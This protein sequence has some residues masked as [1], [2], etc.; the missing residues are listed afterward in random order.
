MQLPISFTE[1]IT[2]QLG[3]EA[4][5]FLAAIESTPSVSIR[6]NEQKTNIVQLPDSQVVPW[7]KS[8]FYLE[9]RPSFTADPLFHAGAYY[10][11]EPSSMLIFQLLETEKY[12]RILDLCAAPGG[13]STLLAAAM[14]PDTL[15]VS[16]EIIRSRAGILAENLSRWG[17]PNVLITNN[18]ASDFGKWQGYFDLIVI[19]APC[20]GEGM[21]RKDLDSR[22]EWSPENVQMCSVRQKRILADI[23]PSLAPDGDLIYST[24]TFSEAENEEIIQHILANYP[25]MEIIKMDFPAE[26]GITSTDFGYRCYPHKVRGEGF[27]FCKLHRK[28]AENADRWEREEEVSW[29]K[30]RQKDK[31]PQKDKKGNFTTVSISDLSKFL[32]IA[33]TETDILVAGEENVF[34]FSEA[35]REGMAD[36]KD[37]HWVKK[38]ILLGKIHGKDFVPSHELAVSTIVKS[39]F[40]AVELDLE[41]ALSYLQKNDLPNNEN[42][43][44]GWLLARYKGVNLGWLKVAGNRLKNHFPI[45]WRIRN[46]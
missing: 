5:A 13:K 10:V 28:V 33:L 46:L 25:E 41:T 12:G 30:K 14:R 4:E 20:S 15:L 40:N 34:Y 16:N 22:K 43:A 42:L 21:F 39:D 24:C 17:N 18:E 19:D 7:H 8:A 32:D 3:N 11:Q 29:G 36:L 31:K 2:S 1:R 45:H 26:W 23:L 27:F 38:G 9:K 35:L 44:N 6:W 37:L